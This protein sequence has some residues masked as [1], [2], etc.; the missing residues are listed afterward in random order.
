MLTCPN[1]GKLI[2]ADSK[3]CTYCGYQLTEADRQ[4]N[5]A[6]ADT[7]PAASETAA[8]APTA[9]TPTNAAAE[10]AGA[11]ADQAQADAGQADA[12]QAT[13]QTAAP[14]QPAQGPAQPQYQQAP[15]QPNPT[16]EKAKAFTKGY[17]AFLVSSLKHPYT[18]KDQFHKYFGF[19]T[20]IVESLFMALAVLVVEHSYLGAT[21]SA[22]DQIAGTNSTSS[23]S[24][25]VFFQGWIMFLAILFVIASV[26]YLTSYA[27]LGDRRLGYLDSLTQF[28]HFSNLAV[29]GAVLSFLVALIAG[30]STNMVGFA[31]TLLVISLALGFMAFTVTIF[32]SENN[33]NLD[34]VYAYLIGTVIL[35]VALWILFAIFK[36][37]FMSQ[38][39]SMTSN[40]LHF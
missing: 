39:S 16:A 35:S 14:E 22:F 3:F 26:A 5:A 30:T 21:T 6:P 17:W 2:P 7:Q 34:R 18:L 11:S 25:A 8:Q 38:L 28:A 37:L 31:M 19:T 32:K 1:C 12:A 24:F 33:T 10:E 29:F 15:A 36:Q 20:L 27:V 40:L 9:D 4:Q 13:D 23:L